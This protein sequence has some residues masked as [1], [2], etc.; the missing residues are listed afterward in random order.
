MSTPEIDPA[1]AAEMEREPDFADEHTRPTVADEQAGT[2]NTRP[3][4]ST[5]EGEGGDGGMDMK[6]RRRDR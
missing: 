6:D 1:T 3:D 5:P 4:E 2:P